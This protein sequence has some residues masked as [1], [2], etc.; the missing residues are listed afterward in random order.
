M[1]QSPHSSPASHKVSL[2]GATFIGVASMLGAGVFVVFS[3]AAA[4]AGNLLLLATALA[5]FVAFLNASSVAKL[6]KL[7]TEPGGTYAFAKHFLNQ[8][9]A[10]L[11]G[12]AFVIG[13]IG[14][15]ASISLA[16]AIYL[17]PEQPV[18]VA[19][20]AV[21]ITTVLN[22]FGVSR[23][24]AAAGL[25]VMPVFILL[26]MVSIGGFTVSRGE[27]LA[28]GTIEG[29]LSASALIFF[30]FA[31]YARVATLG[32]EVRNPERNIPRAMM[33]ALAI[34][35]LLYLSVAAALQR[36]L[37]EILKVNSAP[38]I[39]FS[40]SFLPWI[41]AQLVL[42]VA[43]MSCLAGLLSL[44][45]GVSRTI[46]A[47]A[48]DGELP[49]LLSV[50]SAKSRV[51]VVAQVLLALAVV[52][53]LLVENLVWTIS[54]SSFSILL[55]YF[56]AHLCVLTPKADPTFPQKFVAWLGGLACALIALFA[57]LQGIAIAIGLLAI[58]ALARYGLKRVKFRG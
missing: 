2:L 3:P 22:L 49:R 58:A 26:A 29:M 25:L 1:T 21:L 43:A 56:V 27:A 42:V 20:G 54:V 41:P 36:G 47:M 9:W 12:A 48:L 34:V 23:A 40:A 19:V 37:G 4:L 18:F 44:L 7:V 35:V 11:A 5:G 45:T 24:A 52:A 15:L 39:E 53:L 28:P 31:G 51:P 6:A 17:Y 8:D 10:F 14:S 38:V 32:D 33:I 13:K 55:Y 30:A 46:S 50:K 57:P 16:V